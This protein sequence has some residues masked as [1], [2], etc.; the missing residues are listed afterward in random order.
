MTKLPI[1]G[2]ANAAQRALVLA[3]IRKAG[4][5]KKCRPRFTSVAAEGRDGITREVRLNRLLP[6]SEI[7]RRIKWLAKEIAQ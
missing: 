7:E 2:R 4:I 5:E 1:R 3:A 6:P